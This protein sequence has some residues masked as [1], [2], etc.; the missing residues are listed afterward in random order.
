M[1]IYAMMTTVS[2]P[3]A[4][5]SHVIENSFFCFMPAV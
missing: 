3:I 1:T 5:S 4:M 2:T